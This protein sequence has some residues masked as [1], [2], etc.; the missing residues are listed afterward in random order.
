MNID[1]HTVMEIIDI[2]E[3]LRTFREG[4]GRTE[5]SFQARRMIEKLVKEMRGRNENHTQV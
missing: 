1:D 3:R 4:Y 5:A 2:L